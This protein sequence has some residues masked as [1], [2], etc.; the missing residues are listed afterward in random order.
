MANA[1][2]VV[3]SP[4]CQHPTIFLAPADKELPQLTAECHAVG[5]T[6]Y[7]FLY[8]VKMG[9]FTNYGLKNV[10]ELK[11][12]GVCDPSDEIGHA[13]KN[14]A[15]AAE[16]MTPELKRVELQRVLDHV[17][18]MLDRVEPPRAAPQSTAQEEQQP[19]P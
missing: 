17:Q 7:A 1:K 19:T 4:W 5:L 18:S 12:L 10:M 3:V 11:Y 13:I 16:R 2:L 9:G 15:W 14:V 8:E 6:A